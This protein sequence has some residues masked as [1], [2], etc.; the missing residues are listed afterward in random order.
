MIKKIKS[1][2]NKQYA[3]I[4]LG[5]FGTEMVKALRANNCEVLA[6]DM[7][8][9]RTQEVAEIATHIIVADASEEATLRSIGIDSFDVVIIAI[10]HNIQ[11]SIITA[12]C[13]KELG[14]KYIVAKA[15]NQKHA[16]VLEKIEVNKIVIPEADS[17]LKT[18]RLL[19]YP[20]VNDI[21][22][23]AEGYSI[24]EILIPESWEEKS[25]SELKIRNKYGINVLMVI[26]SEDRSENPTAA[27]VLHKD[28]RLVIGGLTEAVQKFIKQTD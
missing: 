4:G 17:A 5:R 6:V 3:V 12:L 26:Y 25:L 19:C 24:A 14:V 13:C 7:S 8:E 15:F 23:L 22:Q 11:A 10:G 21:I 27:T 18:A 2:D 9:D 20:R 16:K 28:A 1:K